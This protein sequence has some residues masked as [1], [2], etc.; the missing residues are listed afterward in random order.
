MTGRCRPLL[1][2]ATIRCLKC[3]AFAL[4]LYGV[5]CTDGNAPIESNSSARPDQSS[6]PTPT[7][8]DEVF[9][10]SETDV[11]V[12]AGQR[13][14]EP[15]D[16][17]A[18]LVS[19]SAPRDNAAPLYLAALTPI[20]R[21]LADGADSPLEKEVS[22]LADI[23]NLA[24][25]T[26]SRQRIEDVLVRVAPVLEQIDAAQTT[27]KCVFVTGLSVDALMPHALAVQ[28][29]SRLSILQLKQAQKDGDFKQIEA[30]IQRSFRISRDL[31]P[32]GHE[33]CQ[34]VSMAMDGRTLTGI[35]R[36]TLTDS[37]LT[38][39]QLDRL[40]EVLETH[41]QQMLN[42]VEEGLKM[43]YIVS[44]NSIEDLRSGRLTLD[45]IADFLSGLTE[46]PGDSSPSGLPRF[47]YEA[48][49]AACNK[50]FKH[51][52]A[53][54]EK[55]TYCAD[56]LQELRQELQR[57]KS[58]IDRFKDSIALTPPS[59]RA[60][61]RDRAPSF[62]YGLWAA[63]VESLIE[64]EFRSAAQ[65]AGTQMLLILRRY[66]IVHGSIPGNLQE[67]AA[68]SVLKTVQTDPYDGKPLRMAVV[69]GKPTVY[70][71]GKDCQDDGGRADWNFGQEP[72]DYLFVLPS[73]T[74]LRRQD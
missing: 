43:H 26:I 71:V 48:E 62:L 38:V 2:I 49:I 8:P 59:E 24:A 64:A 37:R 28:T 31:Q 39:Q 50:L 68:E 15:F 44:R 21:Y 34:L 73:K 25:G 52:I 20:C 11:P 40:L 67:A 4:L 32:R 19:R 13:V 23:E 35:E 61:L 57:R 9:C 53:A 41:K 27:P 60:R 30:A 16:V 74:Q 56:N 12:W 65:L 17:K 72:G 18:Y 46:Q 6:A 69:S 5:G 22:E 70:S 55:P 36:L 7:S 14:D 3:C 33:V 45:E 47:N 63:P 42:R 1:P 54:A 29:V 58:E 10:T 51:A 66:E